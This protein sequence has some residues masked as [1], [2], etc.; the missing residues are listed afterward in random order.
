MTPRSFP[1]PGAQALSA[2]PASCPHCP[3]LPS[4]DSAYAAVT[5]QPGAW[6][7]V[8]RDLVLRGGLIWV[9][10]AAYDAAT[11]T[12][13]EHRLAHAVAGSTGIEAFVLAWTWWRA[14]R[15]Q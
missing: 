8:A 6:L 5:G 4:S 9:G 2:P 11:G 14:P 12:R 15:G 10:L 3:S 1:R 7:G 13:D